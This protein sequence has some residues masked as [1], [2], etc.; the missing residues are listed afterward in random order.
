[1][2]V[3]GLGVGS[4]NPV[5]SFDV[6]LL[7]FTVV[8]SLTAWDTFSFI[9]EVVLGNIDDNTLEVFVDLFESVDTVVFE[10]FSAFRGST[11]RG[12]NGFATF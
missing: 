2:V 5:L 8:F 1:M 4:I 6:V 7:S 11:V 10:M 3:G 12:V 9:T